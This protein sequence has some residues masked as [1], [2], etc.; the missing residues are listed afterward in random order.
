MFLDR[1]AF[2]K[3]GLAAGFAAG[4]A[5]ALRAS[6][7]APVFASEAQQVPYKFRRREVEYETSEAPGTVVVDTK[8]RFL[9]LVLEGGRAMRFGVGV[10]E[11]EKSWSGEAVIKRKVEWPVWRPTPE[12]IA[13]YPKLARFLPDG[14]PGGAENPLGA[15]A[16]YL[17]QGKVDTLYRIHGTNKPKGIGRKVT[18]G[19]V[20]MLNIDVIYLYERVAIGTRVVVLP[21]A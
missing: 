5:R 4:G 8:N 10:G 19:C 1:R 17:Y 18:S 6:E 11:E 2:V 12:H 21:A 14:M 7:L 9:Y 3:F 20:R 16:M 13:N 15:R